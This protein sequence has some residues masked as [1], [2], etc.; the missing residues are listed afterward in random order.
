MDSSGRVEKPKIFL[1]TFSS[2]KLY[3]NFQ[4]EIGKELTNKPMNKGL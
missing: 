4:P 2:Q 1:S 3:W